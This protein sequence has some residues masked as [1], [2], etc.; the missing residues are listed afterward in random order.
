MPRPGGPLLWVH[1][2]GIGEAGA[3]LALIRA[4]RRARPEVS[5]LLTTNTRTGADGLARMGLPEG[6]VHQY[7]PI[8]TPGAVAAFLNH[9]HPDAFVLAE[10]DLWPRMLLA[11]AARGVPMAMVNARL[12]DRRFAGRLRLSKLFA[13]LL[14]LFRTILVQD[15]TSADRMKVL[16]ATADQTRIAGLLKAA[17]DPLPAKDSDLATLRAALSSRPVWLAAATERREHAAV[18]RAHALARTTIPDLLLILAPRQLT[19]A[20]ATVQAVEAAFKRPPARRSLGGLP[21]PDDAVF[22]ADSMGEMGLWYRVAPVSFIGHSLGVPGDPPLSGKNPFEATL[23]QSVVLHGPRTA[24]F[25]ESY[26]TLAEAGATRETPDAEAMAKAITDLLTDPGAHARH[27]A[28]A[29]TVMAQTRGALPITLQA[30]L[31]LIPAPRDA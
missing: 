17:A 18:L 16:G 30:V 22:L 15:A 1:A 9:W 26:T 31:G 8:D 19:D 10:L 5:V 28:A 4:V 29:D 20:D 11:L 24:N 2:L 21:G 13:P 25:A 6:V 3:M 27:I 23:L 12:T 14:A 7:A